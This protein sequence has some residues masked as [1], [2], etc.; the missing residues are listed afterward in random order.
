MRARDVHH[1]ER[2][3][4]RRLLARALVLEQCPADNVLGSA[5]VPERRAA[6]ASADHLVAVPDDE[7]RFVLQ[8][9]GERDRVPE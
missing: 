1:R 5:G 2:S 6:V 3:E 7:D 9:D 8:I 4:L